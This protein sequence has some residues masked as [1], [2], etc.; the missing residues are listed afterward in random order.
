MALNFIPDENSFRKSPL[1]DNVRS[2][3][4]TRENELNLGD[5]HVFCDF[6]IFNTTEG[7]I[8]RSKILIISQNRGVF[9]VGLSDSRNDCATICEDLEQLETLYDHIYSK[10]VKEKELKS[11]RTTLLFNLESI[12]YC[13]DLVID[14]VLP[15]TETEIARTEHIFVEALKKGNADIGNDIY[16]RL[17]GTIDGAN[18]LIRVKPR[19]NVA[20]G[21][22]GD[23]ANKLEAEITKFDRQQRHGYMI[24]KEGVQRIRGLAG[25][26]KTVILAMKAALTHIENPNATILFTFHTKSLYQHVQK[27]ITRFYRQFSDGSPDFENGI[28]VMHSWGGRSVPGVYYEA[29]IANGITPLTLSQARDMGGNPFDKICSAFLKEKPSPEILYDYSFIDEGQDFPNSFVKLVAQSTKDNRTTWAY[30]ELQNIFQTSLPAIRDVVGS[31]IKCSEDDI[32]L[33]KCYRNP[34]EIIVCAHAIGFGIYSGGK[35]VQ[36]LESKERWKS[37]GYDVLQGN[38]QVGDFMVISRPEENSLK[39]VSEAQTRDDILSCA[40]FQ[41][42]KLEVEHVSRRI[43]QD[44]ESGLRPDDILVVTLDNRHA[45]EYLA[46]M[47]SELYELG[48]ASHNNHQD[49]Y[50]VRDFEQEGMVTLSTINKAKGNE[51]YSVYVLGVDAVSG[52]FSSKN[53]RNMI[54]TALTRAKGWVYITGIGEAANTFRRELESA[55]TIFPRMEFTYTEPEMLIM[56]DMDSKKFSDIAAEKEMDKLIE[57]YGEDKIRMLLL[58]KK[59][60]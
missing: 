40:A 35:I 24:L 23:L 48:I 10:L 59:I 8:V 25:S 29:C 47:A 44:I 37:M 43:K 56:D 55:K 60:N 17:I 28:K 9:L 52:P 1:A 57:Q 14:C 22:R 46:S 54:F 31:D 2:I 6:P 12:L 3:L 4:K 34:R 58:S 51:A 21:S 13:P 15:K 41:T 42:I 26:G 16:D 30:D 20:S 50:G 7:Q 49:S 45:K 18:G 19:R 53:D 39:S 33:Y 36:M 27:L 5:S 38:F 11:G 32:V